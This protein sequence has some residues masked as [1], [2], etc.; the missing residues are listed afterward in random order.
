MK[1]I[2]TKGYQFSELS[3]EAK[4]T[5]INKLWDL[6]VDYEWW[7]SVYEDAA[8]IGLKITGFDIDRGN[9]CKGELKD[10]APEVARLIMVEH[11]KDTPTYKLA[12]SF[13]ADYDKLVEKYS[14]G[15]NLNV[16]AEDNEYDFD[17]DADE[18]EGEFERA[19]LTEY[20]SILSQ[21]YDYLTSREAIVESIEANQYDFTED[22]QLF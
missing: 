11:G 22:G 3:D 14:D 1:T 8:R 15:E 16:V 9:Y 21:E 10:N 20:Q 2:E 18:L 5:A 17:Q 4:E 7:E 13:L 19:L 12:V 6:N